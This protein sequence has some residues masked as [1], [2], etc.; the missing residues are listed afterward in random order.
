MKQRLN[1]PRLSPVYPVE[2]GKGGKTMTCRISCVAIALALVLLA[3]P[4]WA[5]PESDFGSRSFQSISEAL[6]SFAD[7][8]TAGENGEGGPAA[9]TAAARLVL[10]WGRNGDGHRVVLSLKNDSKMG[11]RAFKALF[12]GPGGEVVAVSEKVLLPARGSVSFP[13]D[14]IIAEG[15]WLRGS[16]E[17]LYKGPGPGP[18]GSSRVRAA[19]NA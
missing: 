1:R 18:T 11:P 7:P 2:G 8:F 16:I 12:L 10:P 9:V 19:R 15:M 13:V 3:S 6:E 4:L 5:G 17:I 14:E